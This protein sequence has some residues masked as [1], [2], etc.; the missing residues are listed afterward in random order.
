MWV[1]L[2]LHQN[3]VQEASA[4]VEK[5]FVGT[6]SDVQVLPK[7][8]RILKRLGK[9]EQLV[10]LCKQAWTAHQNTKNA[11]AFGEQLFAAYVRHGN[12]NLQKQVFVDDACS[13]LRSLLLS[14]ERSLK[15]TSSWCGTW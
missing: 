15:M 10:T 12:L 2:L 7:I 6:V 8:T 11:I 14:W 9:D 13:Q 4:F 5:S 1:D 3:K